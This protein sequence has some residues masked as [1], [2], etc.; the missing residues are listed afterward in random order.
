[1]NPIITA[2]LPLILAFIPIYFFYKWMGRYKKYYNIID[3]KIVE[4]KNRT[5][6]SYEEESREKQELRKE[7]LKITNNVSPKLRKMLE[8]RIDV[9]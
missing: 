6:S 1:M 5:F 7:L 9:L 8:V 3:K 4:F 2:V